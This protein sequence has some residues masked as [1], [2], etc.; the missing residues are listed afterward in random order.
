MSGRM[1]QT[2]GE[3]SVRVRVGIVR[4]TEKDGKEA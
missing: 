1:I 2:R 3:Y 4:A